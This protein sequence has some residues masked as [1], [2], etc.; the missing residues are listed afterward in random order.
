MF[1]AAAKGRAAIGT[2]RR[3]TRNIRSPVIEALLPDPFYSL[4]IHQTFLDSLTRIRIY[5]FDELKPIPSLR[6]LVGYLRL[7]DASVRGLQVLTY[8]KSKVVDR[9]SAVLGLTYPNENVIPF[10]QFR[11][12]YYLQ[13]FAS[14]L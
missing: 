11:P 10:P 7:R 6:Y 5:I 3:F 9:N 13:I 2:L 12:L 4:D 8:C 1:K 14:R